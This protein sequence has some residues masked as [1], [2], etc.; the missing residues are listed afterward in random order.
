VKQ[1]L[2][3]GRRREV[4][5]LLPEIDIGVEERGTHDTAGKLFHLAGTEH[6][7]RQWVA[8]RQH[9]KESRENTANAPHV[10]FRQ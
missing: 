3:F 8:G 2:Q 4:S 1:R 7:K 5:A 10:E 9:E 6:Q